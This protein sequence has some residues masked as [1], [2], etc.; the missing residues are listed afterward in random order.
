MPSRGPARPTRGWHDTEPYGHVAARERVKALRPHVGIRLGS[1]KRL[2]GAEGV[3]FE[4]TM[5]V[6]P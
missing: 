1:T 5:G 3:G 4:P 2:L 6:T